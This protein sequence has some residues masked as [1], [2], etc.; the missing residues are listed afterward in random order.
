VLHCIALYYIVL[1]CTALYL[2][3]L[4]CTAL[5]DILLH[6]TALYL[7]VLHCSALQILAL[8]RMKEAHCCLPRMSQVCTYYLG[9]RQKNPIHNSKSRLPEV[10][11]CLL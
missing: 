1:H 11:C 9:I 2:V 4:H 6:C 7:V 10:K 8:N 5:Y 3:V